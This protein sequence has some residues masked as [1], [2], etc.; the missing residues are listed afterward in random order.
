MQVINKL[1]AD[2]ML[3]FLRANIYYVTPE[4]YLF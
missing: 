4:I 3:S 2:S 1:Y